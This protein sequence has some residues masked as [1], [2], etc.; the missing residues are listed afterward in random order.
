M[1]YPKVQG[2][3]P[4]HP[5]HGEFRTHSGHNSPVKLFSETQKAPHPNPEQFD[6]NV[7]KQRIEMPGM[8]ALGRTPSYNDM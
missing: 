6:K 4:D 7:R 1:P 2:I 8:M 3:D 5:R